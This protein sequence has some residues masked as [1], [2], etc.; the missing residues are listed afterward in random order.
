M[1]LS[2]PRFEHHREALGIGEPAPR[3]SWTVTGIDARTQVGYDV[4]ITDQRD[5]AS[6][7]H[8]VDSDASVLVPWP[9]APLLSRERRAVRIKL[10]FADQTESEWSEPGIVETGLLQ[11][12]DWIATFIAPTEGAGSDQDARPAF[13]LRGEFQAEDAVVDA[14]LYVTAL[15]VYEF[16]INGSRV[17]RDVL[18]PGWSSYQDRLRYQT[19]DVT[20]LVSPGRN[21]WGAR[22]ADGWYRGRL[23]FNGGISNIYGD[24]TALVAQLHIRYAD[25]TET[26]HSTDTDWTSHRSEI[27][28][29]SLL[30]GETED[31]R[32]RIP[33]WTCADFTATDWLASHA[34]ERPA[35]ALIAPD[36]PPIREIETIEPVSTTTVAPGIHLI[37][38]GQVLVGRLRITI[39]GQ[40]GRTITLR[41]AE[42]LQNGRLCTEPL[43]HAA[44]TDRFTLSGHGSE[45]FEPRFTTHGFRYVEIE[46]WPGEPGAGDIVAVVLH[47]DMERTAW[48]TTSNPGL[49]RLV[50]NVRWGMRGNFVDVPTDCP[51]RDER[52]GYSG[53]LHVFAPTAATLYDSA[54]FVLNWLG[55]LLADQ[56][57]EGSGIP[58]VFSPD[59]PVNMPFPVPPGNLPAAGWSDAIIGVPWAYYLHYGDIGILQRCYAGMTA[60]STAVEALVGPDQVWDTGFQFGDWLDP[61]APPE[62][63]GASSTDNSL[64]ATAYFAESTRKLASIAHILGHV[65]DADR[66]SRLAD[67]IGIGFRGRFVTSSGRMS[68]DTQA[69][70]ALAIRFNLLDGPAARQ[71]AGDR[72][73]ALVEASGYT[74]ATGFLATPH[75]CD[76]LA[77]TSHLEHAYRLLLQT[78]C[79]SWLY[80]VGMG[81]T[82]VWERWD[83]MLPDG[84]I[85]PGEMTSFNH[86]AFGAIADFIYRRIG[87]IEILEP[88]HRAVRIA[89]RPGGGLTHSETTR[90]TPYGPISVEWVV[91]VSDTRYRV[92]VPA[93][94]DAVLD[95]EGAPVEAV[96]AGRYERT[97]RTSR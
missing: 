12:S 24:R 52:L 51:Q 36:G 76:A 30:D 67:D 55:D 97:V 32:D 29:T 83:S 89:P 31:A 4:E 6:S 27:H 19:Y 9:E 46:N 69:A 14:R 20:E 49:D 73:A 40:P 34:L 58:P 13:L 16:E 23:G 47:S 37:D 33:G 50:E 63:P 2:A 61:S 54:G 88:G 53:D 66:Y 91:G 18:A 25:G 82:T 92:T 68:S 42:V 96:V 85:N 94:I 21:G 44:A 39:D 75:V 59:I 22:L 86:Y 45:T 41:H 95:F 87:G 7:V 57:R 81:A 64:V 3:L 74:V 79:P 90:T 77:D 28:A 48:L 72:L 17:G 78:E 26:V 56:T 8:S 93:G 84:T 43:R 62:N 5:G 11:E 80:Q 71:A 70:Y 10:R 60:W 65:E 1:H 15:G 38:F 35:A